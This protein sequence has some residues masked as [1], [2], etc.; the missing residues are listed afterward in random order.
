VNIPQQVRRKFYTL[1]T[2]AAVLMVFAGAIFMLRPHDFGAQLLI[3]LAIFGSVL[4]VRYS[5]A[6]VWRARGQVVGEWSPATAAKR[7]G[8]L[9]WTLAGSSLIA[10]GVFYFLMYLDQLHGGKVLWPVY[11]LFFAVLALTATS[12]YVIMRIFR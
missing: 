5:N 1:R 12:M 4:I 6:A 2:L 9:A 7:V 3:A 8:R 11:A 10:C